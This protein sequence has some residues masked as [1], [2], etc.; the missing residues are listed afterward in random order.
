MEN[1]LKHLEFIQNVISRM[2]SNSFL[3]KGWAVTLVAALFALA[4][5]DSNVRFIYVAYL[6]VLAFWFLD[7][8][9]LRQEKLYRNLYN[10]VRVKPPEQIDFDLD[11]SQSI[12]EKTC[13]IGVSFSR[14]LT[15]FH[16]SILIVVG[17]VTY[18]LQKG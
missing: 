8:F 15:W 12:S 9:F 17:I 13:F 3:V 2:S 18:V 11:A 10:S 6:P 4:A 5:K 14:T 7:T 16:G 1:K